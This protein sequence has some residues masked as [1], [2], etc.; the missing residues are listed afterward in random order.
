M[1]GGAMTGQVTGITTLNG[2]T[3]IFGTMATTNNT[4]VGAPSLEIYGGT[5]DRLI[6]FAGTSLLYPYS[7]GFNNTGL[8][9]SS[10]ASTSLIFNIGGSPENS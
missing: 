6:L 8:R 1:V 7:F 2:T 5:G 3:G 9:D 10:P 4:N